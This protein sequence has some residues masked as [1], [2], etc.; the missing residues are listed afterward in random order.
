MD[1]DDIVADDIAAAVQLNSRE[2]QMRAFLREIMARPLSELSP[3]S[4][5]TC[6]GALA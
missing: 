6:L 5:A 2:E 4:C 1:I 3:K